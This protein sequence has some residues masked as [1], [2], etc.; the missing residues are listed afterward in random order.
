[1]ADQLILP[2]EISEW[3]SGNG[4]RQ[5]SGSFRMLSLTC[6]AET[7]LK[8]LRKFLAIDMSVDESEDGET[9]CVRLRPNE[10]A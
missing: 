9:C 10:S 7:H 4:G 8:I 3:Q 2:L 1:L 5:R 6:H